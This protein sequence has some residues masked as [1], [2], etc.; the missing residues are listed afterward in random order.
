MSADE[1]EQMLIAIVAAIVVLLAVASV[2]ATWYI[3]SVYKKANGTSTVFG[4][5]YGVALR[6]T[7][8]GVM[9]IPP[10]IVALCHLPRI[11]FTG[12]FVSLALAIAV[13]IPLTLAHRTY[14]VRNSAHKEDPPREVPP[15]TSKD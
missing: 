9:I 10:A 15:F 1:L 13:S 8:A 11:P 14:K 12:L 4:T 5:W 3:R 6:A 7:I 2:P